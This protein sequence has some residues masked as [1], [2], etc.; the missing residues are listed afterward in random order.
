MQ[1]HLCVVLWLILPISLHHSDRLPKFGYFYAN[2]RNTMWPRRASSS[3]C[4][5]GS[6]KPPLSDLARAELRFQARLR[7]QPAPMHSASLAASHWV[8]AVVLARNGHQAFDPMRCSYSTSKLIEQPSRGTARLTAKSLPL[9]PSDYQISPIH[10]STEDLRCGTQ[11][12]LIGRSV[13][14]VCQP[15]LTTYYAI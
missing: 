5:L 3:W 11:L 7:L 15:Y 2:D 8:L 4:R 13:M 12:A 1:L 6:N 14:L 10:C 9:Q